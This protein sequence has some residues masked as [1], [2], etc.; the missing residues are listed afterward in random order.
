MFER[1]P[2]ES[3]KI[4]LSTLGGSALLKFDIILSMSLPVLIGSNNLVRYKDILPTVTMEP[5][6]QTHSPVVDD[7]A[8]SAVSGLLP[9]STQYNGSPD[10]P[11][12]DGDIDE[13]LLLDPDS[14]RTHV[15]DTQFDE[16]DLCP[17]RSSS[18]P[19]EHSSVADITN[20]LFRSASQ[21]RNFKAM[22]TRPVSAKGDIQQG[23]TFG[24]APLLK[25]LD[26]LCG[27]KPAV[28]A[29]MGLGNPSECILLSA[30]TSP[31]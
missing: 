31:H 5:L 7:L 30:R 27:R 12:V 17:E 11:V 22:F 29:A 6:D 16:P 19:Q 20:P 24:K 26:P 28:S 21:Q 23:F 8:S 3:H 10:Q 14:H 13:S 9:Q 18:A 15:T 25:A 2:L 4:C 1:L